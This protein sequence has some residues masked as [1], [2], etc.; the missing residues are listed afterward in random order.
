MANG[1][2]LFA[3]AKACGSTACLTCANATAARGGDAARAMSQPPPRKPEF[4]H[5]FGFDI[6]YFPAAPFAVGR[7]LAYHRHPA[8]HRCLCGTGLEPDAAVR[9][10]LQQRQAELM[11]PA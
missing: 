4:K 11:K 7:T 10:F 3:P 5:E 1:E 9:G 8:R 2:G 6:I